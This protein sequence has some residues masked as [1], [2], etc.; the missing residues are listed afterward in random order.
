MENPEAAALKFNEE[1]E[2]YLTQGNFEKAY[3]SGFSIQL[4]LAIL[5][6]LMII[7]LMK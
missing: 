4:M 2:H 3:A 1:A 7:S 6:S 5:T